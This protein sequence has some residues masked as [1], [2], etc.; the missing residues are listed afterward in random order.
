MNLAK[1]NVLR[2]ERL[3]LKGRVIHNQ[4][5]LQ[6]LPANKTPYTCCQV[7]ARLPTSL[8]LN[9]STDRV[10]TRVPGQRANVFVYI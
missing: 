8:V 2:G 3:L 9:W 4:N 7:E 5:Q 10:L 1:H 6:S